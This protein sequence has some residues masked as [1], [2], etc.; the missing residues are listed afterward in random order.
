MLTR[1]ISGQVDVICYEQAHPRA[2]AATACCVGLVTEIQ[3]FAAERN[4][5]LM[6]V[7]TETL[8]KFGTGTDRA[9]QYGMWI[10]T[11]NLMLKFSMKI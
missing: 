10:E 8:K 7:H 9:F 11:F 2:G 6:P 1:F 4:T 5:E 3:A